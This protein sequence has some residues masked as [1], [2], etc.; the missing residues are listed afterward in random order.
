MLLNSLL[1]SSLCL[2]DMAPLLLFREYQCRNS[3][4]HILT[5][6]LVNP[7]SQNVFPM[8]TFAIQYSLNGGH[9][10]QE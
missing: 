8:K 3:P 2:I 9:P 5:S 7:Y 1:L 4:L 6:V 10:Q